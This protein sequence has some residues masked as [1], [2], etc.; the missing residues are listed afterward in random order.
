MFTAPPRVV[1]FAAAIVL[2][3]FTTWPVLQLAAQIVA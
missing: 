1:A 3:A 2:V